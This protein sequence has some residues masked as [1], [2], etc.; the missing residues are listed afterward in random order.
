MRLCELDSELTDHPT[1]AEDQNVLFS[2]APAQYGNTTMCGERR[3]SQCSA[4]RKACG[5]WE[6]DGLLAW[7]NGIFGGSTKR[8]PPLRVPKP[9]A[10]PPALG[11]TPPPRH[12]DDSRAIAVRDN[13][14]EL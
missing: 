5:I 3:D 7:N 6:H 1:A 2:Q 4:E 12:I 10:P 8:P 14:G 11:T 9:N 13:H